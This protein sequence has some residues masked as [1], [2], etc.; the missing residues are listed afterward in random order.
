MEIPQSTRCGLG[1]TVRPR[2]RENCSRAAEICRGLL[3]TCALT[4]GQS[5]C[6]RLMHDPNYEQD[7]QSERIGQ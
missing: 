6:S 4:P 5:G 1:A 2:N 7:R 3:L